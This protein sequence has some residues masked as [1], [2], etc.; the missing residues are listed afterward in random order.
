MSS[1]DPHLY[2]SSTYQYGLLV[3]FSICYACLCNIHTWKTSKVCY[4]IRE[5]VYEIIKNSKAII[6]I[7]VNA[8][9]VR[10]DKKYL[11]L[12]KISM[13]LCYDDPVSQLLNMLC[14]DIGNVCVQKFRIRMKIMTRI[15]FS[16]HCVYNGRLSYIFWIFFIT[17]L[18]ALC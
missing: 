15:N 2:S 3:I 14:I 12:F 10:D 4:L 1:F 8:Y 18:T 6:I 11:C 17:N 9:C 5:K 13:M 7:S 16:R